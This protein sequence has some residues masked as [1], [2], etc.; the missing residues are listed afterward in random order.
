MACFNNGA[1]ITMAGSASCFVCKTNLESYESV[2]SLWAAQ[3]VNPSSNANGFVSEP[4][5][6][7]HGCFI[8]SVCSSTLGEKSQAYSVSIDKKL[9]CS[10]HYYC[11]NSEDGA[12]IKALNDFKTRSLAL[13]ATLENGEST[14]NG[15]EGKGEISTYNNCSCSQ[16]KF[17]QQ[18]KGY[19]VECF[20]KDCPRRDSFT[21]SY[22]HRFRNCCDLGSSRVSGH[23]TSVAPE[24]F[25]REFFYGVKHWNYCAKEDDVGTVLFTLKP[26]SSPQ[27]KA[28]FR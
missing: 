23:V 17:V 10:K 6:C 24:E 14:E 15:F 13:K 27:S 9:F 21:K 11:Q 16:P 22:E 18:V 26:E 7:H 8:C 5:L 2:V 12:L 19:R 28:Y 4:W 20:E 25:Y 1:I 3:N